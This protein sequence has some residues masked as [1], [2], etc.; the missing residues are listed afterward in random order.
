MTMPALVRA[1]MTEAGEGVGQT[2]EEQRDAQH[3]KIVA[4]EVGGAAP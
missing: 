1:M 3:I 2:K 4:E